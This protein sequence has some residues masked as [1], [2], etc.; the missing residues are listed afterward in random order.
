MCR[1]LTFIFMTFCDL[2]F[3]MNFLS[4]TFELLWYLCQTHN[5]TLGEFELFELLTDP[6][7]QYVETV[8]FE[9]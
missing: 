8:K 7:V 6:K 4:M 1:T 9:I 3:T 5:N 2:T